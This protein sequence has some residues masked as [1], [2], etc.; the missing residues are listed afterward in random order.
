MK[1]ITFTLLLIGLIF[2]MSNANGEEVI[3]GENIAGNVHVSTHNS[4]ASFRNAQSNFKANSH[5][6]SFNVVYA[7]TAESAP[8]IKI[9]SHNGGIEVTTPANFSASV[10]LSTHNGSIDTSLPITVVGK[11]SRKK[12]SGT[13]GTGQ[14]GKLRLETHNGS[15]KIR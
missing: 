11:V 1:K 7:R 15:I 5:N 10:H 3:T 9:T 8:D 12:I 4:P 14:G 13:I 2:T 6:G